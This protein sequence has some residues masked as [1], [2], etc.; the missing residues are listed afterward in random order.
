MK[1]YKGELPDQPE[2]KKKALEK[3]VSKQIQFRTKGRVLK[4][5]AEFEFSDIVYDETTGGFI[6][7]GIS[8]DKNDNGSGGTKEMF[9]LRTD[10]SLDAS[11]YET[12]STT[13]NS[14]GNP[15]NNINSSA[16][17]FGV[18]ERSLSSNYLLSTR[19]DYLWLVDSSGGVTYKQLSGTLDSTY[20]WIDYIKQSY[21]T[22]DGGFLVYGTTSKQG[23]FQ[24]KYPV[25]AKLDASLN[26]DYF[27][28]LDNRSTASP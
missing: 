27:K 8:I 17:Q 13:L 9:H 28:V 15:S 1:Y 11:S 2:A 14:W 21:P 10:S 18:S 23:N 3:Y 22:S 12:I 4:Y 19:S 25:I 6:V 7:A 26:V 24:D 20:N 16:H 5:L